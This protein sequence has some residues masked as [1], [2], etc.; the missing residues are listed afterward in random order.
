MEVKTYR[1]KSYDT[2][3]AVKFTRENYSE[4]KDW[5]GDRVSNLIIPKCPGCVAEIH[6]DSSMIDSRVQIVIEEFD[7]ILLDYDGN[8]HLCDEWDF[9]AAYEEV[10]VC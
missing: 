9:K 3:K 1:K 6:V 10:E 7:Y 8:I 2:I 5:L 4:I